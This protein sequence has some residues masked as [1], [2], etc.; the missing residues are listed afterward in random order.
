MNFDIRIT[1]CDRTKRSPKGVNYI[2]ATIANF[3]CAG[4]ANSN[5]CS[6]Y[7]S[8]PETDYV[9]VYCDE[10]SIIPAARALDGYENYMRACAVPSSCDILMILEDD[11]DFASNFLEK[12]SNWLEKNYRLLANNIVT[13]YTPYDAINQCLDHGKDCWAYPVVAFYGTQAILGLPMMINECGKFIGT[14]ERLP[15][16]M[17]IKE[18]L[19]ATRRGI[20]STV[21]CF[22]QHIGMIS[23][24]HGQQMH[25]TL[26]FLR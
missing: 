25:R 8:H 18:W 10:F 9:N 26:G 21:P 4:G 3:L 22:V 17:A 19:T 1:T 14:V 15:Y 24:I 2:H 6:L 13:L 20:I 11:L 16:D 7:V 23:S 5:P 12:V